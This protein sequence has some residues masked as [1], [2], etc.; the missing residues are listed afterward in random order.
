M[1]PV[2]NSLREFVRLSLN[3]RLRN[4]P[5]REVLS[6]NEGVNWRQLNDKLSNVIFDLNIDQSMIARNEGWDVSEVLRN[7]GFKEV[8]E[9]RNRIA[10]LSP[11]GL[12]VIKV[13]LSN[14]G[15]NDNESEYRYWKK[16]KTP[17][18][19][20]RGYVDDTLETPLARCRMMGIFLVMEFVDDD[21]PP[22]KH[23]QWSIYV[24]CGQ[25]GVNRK[26]RVVAYDYA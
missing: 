21:V 4:E 18:K 10:F 1:N 16:R 8:G 6:L 17:E 20:S 15:V 25:I 5:F 14:Y 24:D 7:A 12:N 11:T 2:E 19:S 23:P 13:P 9:G 22:E 26:G 3:E